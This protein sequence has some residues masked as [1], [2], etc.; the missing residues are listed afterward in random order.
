M[1]AGPANKGEAE[2]VSVAM[3]YRKATDREV[4]GIEHLVALPTCAGDRHQV[5]MTDKHT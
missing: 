1:T 4:A 5:V 3:A 2:A